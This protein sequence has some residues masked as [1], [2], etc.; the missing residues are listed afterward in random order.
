M[1][2]VCAEYL[3]TMIGR[4]AFSEHDGKM[5]VARAVSPSKRNKSPASRDKAMDLAPTSK[6][7]R[8]CLFPAKRE[9]RP[10]RLVQV[11]SCRG[12]AEVGNPTVL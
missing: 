3:Q 6:A 4:F 2:P 11:E 12:K 9:R 10:D 8:S 1:N 7:E 5:T